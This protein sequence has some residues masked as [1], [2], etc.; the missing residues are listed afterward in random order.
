MDKL[1][2]GLNIAATADVSSPVNSV[3]LY[4]ISYQPSDINK[5]LAF[6]YVNTHPQSMMIDHTSCGQQLIALGMQTCAENPPEELTKIW[7]LA[8]ERFIK[9]AS[10][11]ITAFVENADRRSTFLTVELPL[12]LQNERITLINGTDKFVFAEKFGTF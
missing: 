6:E 10:G 11:N 3:V 2:Q 7:R 5:K 12:I 1:Q 4:S 9:S 8:S